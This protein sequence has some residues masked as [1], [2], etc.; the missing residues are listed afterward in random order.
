VAA[1]EPLLSVSP[2]FFEILTA[3]VFRWFA[4]IAVDAAVVEVGL[5]GRRDAT[6]VADGRVAVVTNVSLDHEEHFGSDLADIAEEKAGIVKP[7]ST[8][9]LGER[10]PALADVFRR[11]GADVVVERGRDFECTAN[12]LAHGGRLLHLRTPGASYDG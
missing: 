11:A 6:N 12:R 10:D 7:G 4:D 1:L 3:A 8:L 9:V 5:G 2:S